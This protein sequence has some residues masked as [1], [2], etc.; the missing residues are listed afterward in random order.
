MINNYLYECD[1][2]TKRLKK[3]NSVSAIEIFN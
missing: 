1:T 2:I 3:L